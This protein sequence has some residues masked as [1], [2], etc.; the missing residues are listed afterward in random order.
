MCAPEPPKPPDY[1]AAAQV[2]AGANNPNIYTPF[3]S[4]VVTGG[5]PESQANRSNVTITLSPEQQ[6][7]YNQMVGNQQ[8][9]GGTAGML[10]GDIRANATGGI[11][12][13]TLDYSVGTPTG[14]VR[15]VGADDFSKDRRRVENAIYSRLE[16]QIQRDRQSLDQKLANQGIAMGSEAYK[17]AMNDQGQRENDARMQA[18]LAGGQEQSRLFDLD[19][20]QGQFANQAQNQLYNQGLSSAQ[21]QNQAAQQDLQQQAYMN[22]L[23]LQTYNTLMTGAQPQMP[24]FQPYQPTN[25]LQAA[26]MQGNAAMNQYNA[27][28]GN[29]NAMM[30]GLFDLGGAA[31]MASDIRLKSNIRK[32]GEKK[33][34]GVYLYRI[35]GRWEIGVLAQEVLGVMP[36]AVHVHPSGYLMVNYGLING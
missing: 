4:Q 28:M 20:S 8:S 1:Q 33:G 27:Q 32:I 23:P 35:F 24:Q 19:L 10:L 3:G 31:I 6:A 7:L 22:N 36:E 17:N 14:A 5:S 15:G 16:P 12:P 21:F 13:R 30:G 18:I 34:L 11:D 29:R 26:G 9:L 25:Y 2:E